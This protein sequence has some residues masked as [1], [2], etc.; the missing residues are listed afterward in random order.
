MPLWLATDRA[1]RPR[2]LRG[3]LSKSPWPCGMLSPAK[4]GQHQQKAHFAKTLGLTVQMPL[5]PGMTQACTV[6]AGVVGRS[7]GIP[8][9]A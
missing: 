3:P 1:S 9:L 2:S 7:H 8:A 5:L 6:A 4:F